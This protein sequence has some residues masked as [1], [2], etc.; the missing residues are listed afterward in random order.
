MIFISKAQARKF[1]GFHYLGSVSKAH[2]HAKSIHYNELT[3]SL[4]LSPAN[5]SGYEVCPNRSAECTLLCL[6]GSGNGMVYPDHVLPSRIK[7][8]KL[9]FEQKELFVR[10]MI[11]ASHNVKDPLEDLLQ[12]VEAIMIAYTQSLL[13]DRQKLNAAQ[14]SNDVAGA[15]EILQDIFRTD[16][17]AI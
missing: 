11:D 6:N 14:D 1:T 10:W 16:L 8:T 9:F 12:S 17:R 5:S 7:K 13:I 15:Q 4:Y 2:K 3:Y